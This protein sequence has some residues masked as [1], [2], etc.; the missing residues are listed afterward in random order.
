MTA[1]EIIGALSLLISL[2]IGLNKLQQKKKQKF[3]DQAV[4]NSIVIRHDQS[5]NG[6]LT[7][8]AEHATKIT[9]LERNIE[10]HN[11]RLRKLEK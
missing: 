4:I 6:L 11:S 2:A 5:F 10:K 1:A 8:Q 3:A 9:R 7:T